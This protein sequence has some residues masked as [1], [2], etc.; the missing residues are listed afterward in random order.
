VGG[1]GANG[2]HDPPRAPQGQAALVAPPAAPANHGYW[3]IS[4]GLL[5]VSVIVAAVAMNVASR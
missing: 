4:L 5:C 3:T 1:D 2:V